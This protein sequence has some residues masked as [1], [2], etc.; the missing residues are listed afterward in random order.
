MAYIFRYLFE[1]FPVS[2]QTINGLCILD[3]FCF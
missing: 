1:F 3:G 2:F